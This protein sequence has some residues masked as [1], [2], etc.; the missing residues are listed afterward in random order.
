MAANSG[1]TR[2]PIG[3]TTAGVS[4]ARSIRRIAD[5]YKDAGCE[6][7][8]QLTNRAKKSG[9][10]V[11]E[12]AIR[13]TIIG[14]STC[15]PAVVDASAPRSARVSVS[16]GR[17]VAKM[18]LAKRGTRI[19]GGGKAGRAVAVMQLAKDRKNVAVRIV[20][21]HAKT[22]VG[23][24]DRPRLLHDLHQSNR[25]LGRQRAYRRRLCAHHSLNP[26]NSQAEPQGSLRDG[27]GQRDQ[28]PNHHRRRR[29]GA[30]HTADHRH[31]TCR[32]RAALLLGSVTTRS[33]TAQ[34]VTGRRRRGLVPAIG[35]VGGRS[36][37]W[38]HAQSSSSF[39]RD[40]AR[41]TTAMSGSGSKSRPST[42]L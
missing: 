30:R 16:S 40:S 6:S 21:V 11:Q 9:A 27:Y 38:R 34:A 4:A 2:G 13:A 39:R 25:V 33:T 12:R 3:G 41:R 22:L 28:R 36:T 35:P 15:A 19:F 23:V 42:I 24:S 5:V 26:G 7:A 17:A 8:S 10:P 31:E 29:F 32:R 37:H 1:G 14:L 20:R 18:V